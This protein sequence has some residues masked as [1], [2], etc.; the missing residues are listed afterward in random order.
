MS[1]ER[2]EPNFPTSTE[3]RLDGRHF[4]VSFHLQSNLSRQVTADPFKDKGK[5]TKVPRDGLSHTVCRDSLAEH[6]PPVDLKNELKSDYFYN[7]IIVYLELI[8][9]VTLNSHMIWG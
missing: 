2:G 6:F 9:L 1:V 4:V 7:V 5:K 8:G 3:Y